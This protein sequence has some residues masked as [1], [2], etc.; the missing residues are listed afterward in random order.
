MKNRKIHPGNLECF[1]KCYKENLIKA[2]KEH[3]QEYTWPASQ[4]DVVFN[5]MAKAIE[6]GS[7]NKD[8]RAIKASCKELKIK[9]TYTAIMN[10]ISL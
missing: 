8:S 5:R 10:F 9:H 7:F 1:L 4:I 6:N 3:P 2:Q